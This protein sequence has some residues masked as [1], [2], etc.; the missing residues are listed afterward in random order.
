MSIGG[1]RSGNT[2]MSDALCG[3]TWNRMEAAVVFRDFTEARQQHEIAQNLNYIFL[4]V[5]SNAHN[6][7]Q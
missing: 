7:S 1:A 4:M 6:S 3:S 5:V 2:S